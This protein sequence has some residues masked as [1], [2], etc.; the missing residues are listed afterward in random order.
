[1]TRDLAAEVQHLLVGERARP[2]QRVIIEPG[3]TADDSVRCTRLGAAASYW[4]SE[5][6]SSDSTWLKI[7]HLSRL[8][9][10]DTGD[11][12]GHRWE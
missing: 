10:D 6:H 12:L 8:T 9:V 2:T 4:S 7:I 11:S 1:M 3:V 5:P